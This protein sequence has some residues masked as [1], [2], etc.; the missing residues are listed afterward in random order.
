[1]LAAHIPTLFF[2]RFFNKKRFL[3]KN[4]TKTRNQDR[5][6]RKFEQKQNFS[7]RKWQWLLWPSWNVVNN[8]MRQ[9]DN[10]VWNMNVGVF[11]NQSCLQWDPVQNPRVAY[12]M[13]AYC[14]L[15]VKIILVWFQTLWNL[16]CH[17]KVKIF[18]Q[19]K[20]RSIKFFPVSDRPF[21]TVTAQKV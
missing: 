9:L 2:I 15:T 8:K 17:R 14:V 4:S 7:S 21:K 20:I 10:M 5:K 12:T 11:S 3:M 19:A 1:M 6:Q 18:N 16:Q 13:V